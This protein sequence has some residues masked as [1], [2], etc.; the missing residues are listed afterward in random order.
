MIDEHAACRLRYADYYRTAL[1]HK[2]EWQVI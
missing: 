2:P 1:R